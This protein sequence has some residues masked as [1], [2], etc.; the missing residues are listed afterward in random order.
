MKLENDGSTD[1]I[2][3]PAEETAHIM[4][5]MEQAEK[6]GNLPVLQWCTRR[7]LWIYGVFKNDI[8]GSYEPF[9]FEGC[10]ITSIE[11][12]NAKYEKEIKDDPLP[13]GKR[14]IRRRCRV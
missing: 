2:H 12:F 13:D 7:L 1:F 8:C 3:F 4:S 10:C 9:E 6:T 5:A 11:D 14:R